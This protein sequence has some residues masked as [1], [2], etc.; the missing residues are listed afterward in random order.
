LRSTCGHT[1]LTI[2]I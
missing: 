2:R 1:G